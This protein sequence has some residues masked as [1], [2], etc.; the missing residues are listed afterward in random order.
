MARRHRA[1][2]FPTRRQ[3]RREC[4]DGFH[5][6][7]PDIGPGQPELPVMTDDEVLRSF[8]SV[9]GELFVNTRMLPDYT[10]LYVVGD[11][12]A[13]WTDDDGNPV[14]S[15]LNGFDF[16]SLDEVLQD[17]SKQCAQELHTRYKGILKESK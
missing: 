10:G 1:N 14:D 7:E 16:Q 15:V 3:P 6:T 4:K 12:A 9:G 13:C 8:R 5:P 2:V 11:N 17:H